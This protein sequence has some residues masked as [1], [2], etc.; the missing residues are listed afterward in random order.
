MFNPRPAVRRVPI[1]AGETCVVVDDFLLD[2]HAMV[3]RAQAERGQFA[4]APGF[5]PGPERDLG[6]AVAQQL[7]QFFNQHVRAALGARRTLAAASRLSLASCPVE[8]L[9]P[10]Q[11]LCH[12]DAVGLGAAE[13]AGAMVAYLFQDARLG[14]TSFFVPKRPL[15][16]IA[17]MMRMARGMDSAAFTAFL[18]QA[19]AYPIG[20]NSWFEHVAEV[21]AAW[22]RAVF[23]NGTVFHSGHITAPELLDA[24]PARGRLTMNGFFRLRLNAA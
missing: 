3:A 9:A 14:G 11:R 1:C 6:P 5:Y 18:G 8:R 22:N 4:Q 21:P 24:D 20:S 23:Y 7:E 12:R 2:P 13:G 15:D 17:A 10:L 19:P 16:E